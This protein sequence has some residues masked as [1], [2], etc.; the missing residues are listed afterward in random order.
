MLSWEDKEGLLFVPTQYKVANSQTIMQ[1]EMNVWK[2]SNVKEI[3]ILV[4]I[5]N[6]VTFRQ[7]AVM[8]H[9]L[10]V[11][12]NPEARIEPQLVKIIT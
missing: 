4:I 10:Y 5:G 12:F 1:D 8:S 11:I 3:K 9:G 7:I 6:L 2:T